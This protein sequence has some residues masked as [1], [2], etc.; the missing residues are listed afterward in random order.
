MGRLPHPI[1]LC[2]AA[3]VIWLASWASAQDVTLSSRDGAI[4]VSGTLIGYDGEFYRVD[5]VF[6]ALTLDAQGVDC[7]GPGCPDLTAFVAEI[8]LSGAGGPAGGLLP[9]LIADFAATQGYAHSRRPLPGA[10][11]EAWLHELSDPA[12]GRPQI[13]FTLEIEGND[14]GLVKLM[15]GDTDVA[16]SLSELRDSD[17]RALLVARDAVVPIVGPGNPVEAISLSDL[18]AV[19]AGQIV[20]WADLGW[21]D[22]PIVVHARPAASGVQQAIETLILAPTDWALT[23]EAVRH[24]DEVALLRA[25][26]A[27]PLALSVA[28]WSERGDARALH[29]REGCGARLSPDPMAVKSE[30]YPLVV[31]VLMHTR[32]G[33][34]P[35]QLRR[36]ASHATGAAAQAAI[37]RGGFVDQ[38]PETRPV[39]AQGL[40]L[41]RAIQAAED[42]AAFDSLRRLAAAIDGTERLSTSFRFETGAS[43][44]D[45]Q[46]RSNVLALAR[47]LEAGLHDGR[48]L[49]FAGFSDGEGQPAAN[50]RLSLQRARTVRDAVLA[51]APLLEPEQ[52]TITTEGFGASLPIACDD[53]EWGRRVNRRV[54]VWLR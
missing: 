33:R 48:E 8:G 19:L 52:V 16:L 53:T 27:D 18:A 10:S 36:F 2:A 1:G 3:L 17:V 34:L 24:P 13:R 32:T 6:G 50:Q 35:L 46:S 29:L 20:N 5:S 44:L 45:V 12:S 43:G 25:V 7:E 40:R 21:I 30:D 15:S 41:L 22:A 38:A 11:G 4:S 54:E 26:A 47:D 51:A 9:A 14:T 49:V 31:P 37:R 39:E 28:F 23:T 42:S